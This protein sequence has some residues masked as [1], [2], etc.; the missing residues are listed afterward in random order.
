M[1]SAS[2]VLLVPRTLP[3]ESREILGWAL[4]RSGRRSELEEKLPISDCRTFGDGGV[5]E[6][7]SNL[8]DTVYTMQRR[9]AWVREYLLEEGYEPRSFVGLANLIDDPTA[10]AA[11]IRTTLGL[12]D[13]WAE[14]VRT[15]EDALTKIFQCAENAGILFVR[16][17]VVGNSSQRVCCFRCT[18]CGSI[19]HDEGVICGDLD[20]P[21]N[22]Y[23]ERV[24][25]CCTAGELVF[26]HLC[27]N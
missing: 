8:L 7:S 27:K 15:W 13:N 11:Y 5:P 2:G 12:S 1:G 3:L 16:N 25:P 9:R 14:D 20:S 18:I 23:D 22:K 19:R 24:L 26:M 17:G 6:P 10:I 4:D 21:L